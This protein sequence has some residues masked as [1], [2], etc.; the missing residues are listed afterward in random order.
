MAEIG[1]YSGMAATPNVPSSKFEGEDQFAR[2][3]ARH[4]QRR[5]KEREEQRNLKIGIDQSI[6]TS[7]EAGEI[8]LTK[9]DQ[10][11]HNL[12]FKM[13]DDYMEHLTDLMESLETGYT[14]EKQMEIDKTRT[15][16][17]TKLSSLISLGNT[18]N[19]VSD[20]FKNGTYDN[21]LSAEV[22]TGLLNFVKD[23]PVLTEQIDPKT[24]TLNGQ[25]LHQVFRSYANLDKLTNMVHSE[26]DMDKFVKDMLIEGEK[27]TEIVNGKEVVKQTYSY[28]E[29]MSKAEFIKRF[30][31]TNQ[32][33]KEAIGVR[34]RY[35]DPDTPEEEKIAM[36]NAGW[37]TKNQDG[38]ATVYTEN[39]YNYIRDNK[40]IPLL[41]RDLSSK[42]HEEKI[43]HSGD[44]AR[45]EL[46]LNYKKAKDAYAVYTMNGSTGLNGNAI[47]IYGNK[48]V[49]TSTG[50]SYNPFRGSMTGRVTAARDNKGAKEVYTEAFDMNNK[51]IQK[52]AKATYGTAFDIEQ[53]RQT[54]ASKLGEKLDFDETPIS[55]N[56]RAEGIDMFVANEEQIVRS[57]LSS[58][59]ASQVMSESLNS[60]HE[61]ASQKF[62]EQEEVI[63]PLDAWTAELLP[64]GTAYRPSTYGSFKKYGAGSVKQLNRQDGD[65]VDSSGIIAKGISVARVMKTNGYSDS[66]IAKELVKVS[67]GTSD[68]ELDIVKQTV[69]DLSEKF[70]TFKGDLQARAETLISQGLTDKEVIDQLKSNPKEK[71]NEEVMNFKALGFDDNS[72]KSL[73]DR[74]Q[75]KTDEQIQN[76]IKSVRNGEN[77]GSDKEAV[78]FILNH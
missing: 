55:F 43:D 23:I 15:L 54:V 8:D 4:F 21:K 46:D 33:K 32:Y 18:M 29:K 71:Y 26:V 1:K 60:V 14:F 44:G 16:F 68:F 30:E 76:F 51:G 52:L 58:T 48:A 77:L 49:I 65:I 11:F 25:S 2:M 27:N 36:E 64:F 57:R 56:D 35:D 38:S 31:G 53:V 37:V 10:A 66:E 70:P 34:E 22:G 59:N 39:L 69:G 67:E 63:A 61:Y 7:I 6:K 41:N 74:Y 73:K 72:L 24:L 3:A 28:D 78:D 5:E 17:Q 47:N 12:A 45:K 9:V 19:T 50:L 40:I 13:S 42:P 20:G 62:E 75:F